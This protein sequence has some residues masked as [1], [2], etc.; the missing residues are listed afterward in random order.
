[1][2]A[3]VARIGIDPPPLS[4]G[5]QTHKHV[6]PPLSVGQGLERPHRTRITLIRCFTSAPTCG[7]VIR[8][9]RVISTHLRPGTT[10]PE[11]PSWTR[12]TA[13]G[14]YQYQSSV[15]PTR[16]TP[17]C[18]HTTEYPWTQPA[19]GSRSAPP[20]VEFT[21]TRAMRWSGEPLPA[22]GPEAREGPPAR[23]AHTGREETNQRG[24]G[25][26]VGEAEQSYTA[27]SGRSAF[28]DRQRLIYTPLHTLREQTLADLWGEGEEEGVG[29]GAPVRF[30]PLHG[31]WDHGGS[32]AEGMCTHTAPHTGT[33][34]VSAHAHF[35]HLQPARCHEASR[36]FEKR[37]G[38]RHSSTDGSDTCMRDTQPHFLA[39]KCVIYMRAGERA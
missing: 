25:V 14:K 9:I 10:R 33:G 12:L 3:I 18:T 24:R 13:A 2:W 5:P 23:A 34:G 4:V 6:G 35:C 26:G 37:A 32:H 36:T 31:P 22:A 30:P 17:R 20:R 16:V 19:R 27:R 7:W 15:C 8:V 1:V 11:A 39:T 38:G 29:H 28:F 21:S